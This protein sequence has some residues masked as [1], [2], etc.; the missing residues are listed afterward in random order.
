MVRVE[1]LAHACLAC[2]DGGEREEE[3]EQSIMNHCSHARRRALDEILL[4]LAGGRLL[5]PAQATARLRNFNFAR[6][7]QA[8]NFGANEV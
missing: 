4:V 5:E 6:S 2:V 7:L 8:A 1:A 3:Q